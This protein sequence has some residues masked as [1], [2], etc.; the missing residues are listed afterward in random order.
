MP[1]TGIALAAIL[2]V[3]GVLSS[4]TIVP[5]PSRELQP[6][7]IDSEAIT[8]ATELMPPPQKGEE[9]EQERLVQKT[10]ASLFLINIY[11]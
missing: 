9:K 5:E 10:P 4:P 6:P 7:K 1:S 3:G 11:A 2:F 8:L